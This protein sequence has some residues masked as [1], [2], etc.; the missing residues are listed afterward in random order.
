M[1]DLKNERHEVAQILRKSNIFEPVNAEQMLPD[2]TPSWRRISTELK[3]CDFFVLILGERYGWIPDSGDLAG[4]GVSVTEAE[5]RRARELKIPVLP[6]VRKSTGAPSGTPDAERR[7]KFRKQIEEW[8]GGLFRGQ[9]EYASDLAESALQAVTDLAISRVRSVRVDEDETEAAPSD[10]A[11]APVI[12]PPRLTSALKA[13][14]AVLFA[15]SGI[16]LAAGL[17]TSITFVSRLVG[18]LRSRIKGYAAPPVGSGIAS[19]AADFE[20][21]FG[22]QR[23][24]EE[25]RSL[26][27]IRNGT[28]FT[29][30]HEAAV[31]LFP[32]IITTNYDRLFERAASKSSPIQHIIAPECPVPLPARFIL[33]LHGSV[34][35]PETLVITE[36]D[37]IAFP[38]TH[39]TVLAEVANVLQSGLVVVAGSS[40]RDSTVFRLFY[41]LR[42][43]LQGYC[44]LPFADELST[45][46]IQSLGLEPIFGTM[47]SFFPA[48]QQAGCGRSASSVAINADPSS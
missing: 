18:G 39:K 8:E 20:M 13:R 23:L 38:E 45:R 27:E 2:G 30:A 36:T 1:E 25:V 11:T 6:F 3:S 29:P 19:V 40:L 43:A 17:P 41:S 22:R 5:Y 10:D 33:K 46:R 7:E 35:K 32:R 34:L 47:E 28:E 4:Q 14:Q 37:L 31:D 26:L 9:F 12:I 48:L 15:G 42:G 16:S 21:K 24:A 44:L